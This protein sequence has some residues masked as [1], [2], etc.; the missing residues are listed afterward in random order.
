MWLLENLKLCM[1]LPFVVCTVFLLGSANLKCS[2]FIPFHDKLQKMTFNENK[3]ET[4]I[5]LN[6]SLNLL[7]AIF[8]YKI[9]GACDRGLFTKHVNVGYP[10]LVVLS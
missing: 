3:L 8:K 7:N 2:I 4:L 6:N 10:N 1:W 9:L 5:Y